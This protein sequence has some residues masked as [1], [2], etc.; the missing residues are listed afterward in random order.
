MK[1]LRT[2]SAIALSML[3]FMAQATAAGSFDD[4]FTK[5]NNSIKYQPTSKFKRTI[6]V[7]A[8]NGNDSAN[9]LKE[10]S[11]IKSINKLSDM[12]L[13]VGDEVLLK[14]G[15]KHHGTINLTGIKGGSKKNGKCLHIGSYGGEKATLDFSGYPDGV[16]IQS[17]SN[18]TIS[19]LKITANGSPDPAKHMLRDADAKTRDRIGIQ[20]TNTWY[21]K[22]KPENSPGDMNN[23]TI[24][25][26]D[27][28]DIFYYNLTD[29]DIPKNRPCRSWSEPSVNYGYAIKG[30]NAAHETEIENVLVEECTVRHVSNMGVQLTGNANSIFNN[31]KFTKCSFHKT[32]GP[33]YMFANCN[34]VILEKSKTYYSGSFDDPRKWGRGSGMWLMNC[35]GF[36]IQHNHFEGASGI[37]DSCGAHIDHGNKNVTIQYCFSKNNA[38]GFVEVLGKNL[39]CSYRYNISVD[40]G[41]RNSK[42]NDPEQSAQYWAGTTAL[43]LG[44][45][46]SVSGYTGG[47]FIGPYQTYIYNNTIVNTDKRPDGF[48]NPFVFQVTTSST[49][50]LIANNIFYVPQQ[51]YSGWSQHFATKEGVKNVNNKA[52]DYATGVKKK[53]QYIVRKFTPKEIEAMDHVFENNLYK[54]YDPKF[55]LGENALPIATDAD[56]KRVGYLDKNALGGNPE[57]ANV[58]GK[59]AEDFIPSNK[60]V[61][62]RGIKIKKLKSDKTS[63]GLSP[64]SSD[65]AKGT[66][67][68]LEMEYDFFG[69][70]ITTPIIGAVV[71]ATK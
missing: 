39:N 25:N 64:K 7:D 61:I 1:L 40:D 49:G 58:D 34:N 44:T 29:A 35:D 47:D 9:G 43:T 24:Y 30:R 36:L 12:N 20:I 28:Y 55:P 27:F 26:V 37:G 50:V 68:A 54:L 52:Y 14:G 19:D 5:E 59:N 63:Y 8:V 48:I 67:L 4:S 22:A 45:L 21:D 15:Q 57:F 33:G 46:I 69:R 38:G 70:K 18:I 65:K 23:I 3:C 2:L 66:P 13:S 32:G 31:V 62:E 42:K 51:M 6:Y 17:S 56:G 11:A 71:P 60:E 41:W 10:S 53:D 16:T